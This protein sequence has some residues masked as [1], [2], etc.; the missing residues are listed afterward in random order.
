M[1]GMIKN[2]FNDSASQFASFFTQET[3]LSE[4]ELREIRK[5]I[6]ERIKNK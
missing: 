2:F 5:L 1:S 3:D 6:D 4:K